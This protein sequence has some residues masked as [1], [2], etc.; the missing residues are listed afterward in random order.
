[1]MDKIVL[2]TNYLPDRQESMV[3]FG[4]TMRDLLVHRD[5]NRIIFWRPPEIFRKLSRVLP[6]RAIK[7]LAYVDKFGIGALLLLWTRL[8]TPNAIWHVVDH[9]NAL[10][11]FLLPP[12][13]T[14]VTCHDCIAIDD[15]LHGRTGQKVGYFGPL[16]QRAIMTGLQRAG[17][18]ACVSRATADDL[19]RLAGPESIQVDVVP[20]GMVQT[21]SPPPRDDAMHLLRRAGIDVT[22][23]FLFM[24]GSDLRRK[25][26]LNVI[27]SFNLLRANG[28]APPFQLVFA[29]KPMQRENRAAADHSPWRADIIEIGNIDVTT[30]AA[31]YRYSSVVLFPSLAEGFGLPIIEAQLCG[32]ALVTSRREPMT[33]IAGDGAVLVDPEDPADIAAGVLRA[34]AEEDRLR[35]RGLANVGRF[36]PEKMLEGYLR[37]YRKLGYAA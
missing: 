17:A 13:E 26:R 31:A 24:V 16:F 29:G 20:N 9:G 7:W 23:P 27:Q 28:M 2:I 15:A 22:R 19:V 25:N 14:V 18:V 36:S 30:L 33:D 34:L 8:R 6:D 12:N 11:T 37:I 5:P 1:M 4:T 3:R 10:Y 35:Q 21:L 32:A